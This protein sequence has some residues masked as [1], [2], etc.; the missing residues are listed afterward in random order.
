MDALTKLGGMAPKS[1]AELEV[2]VRL[3]NILKSFNEGRGAK[4]PRLVLIRFMLTTCRQ[5]FFSGH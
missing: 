3:S 2:A 5:F 1:V 4:I